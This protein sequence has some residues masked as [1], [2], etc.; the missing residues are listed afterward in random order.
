MN[1]GGFDR[2][3]GYNTDLM[4][5]SSMKNVKPLDVPDVDGINDGLAEVGYREDGTRVYV[6]DVGHAGEDIAQSHIAASI[7]GEHVDIMTPDIAYDDFYGKVL[8]EEMPGKVRDGDNVRNSSFHEAVAYKMLMGD[9]DYA[10]NILETE[11]GTS[12]AVDFDATG[13]DLITA[14]TTLKTGIGERINGDILHSEASKLADQIDTESLEREMREEKYLQDEW[15]SGVEENDPVPWEG[16]FN[17]SIDN[18]IDNVEIFQT[19]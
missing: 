5:Y 14:K 4:S 10:G 9:T 2:G 12:S 17:G 1:G 13:R 15:T 8:M 18:I 6:K 11:Y 16:L 7:F 19:Q 3:A